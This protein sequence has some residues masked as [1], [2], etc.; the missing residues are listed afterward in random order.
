M[1]HWQDLLGI[2]GAKVFNNK[3]GNSR[4]ADKLS[5]V[6]SLEYENVLRLN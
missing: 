1:C 2:A 6:D 5:D 4:W 3:E